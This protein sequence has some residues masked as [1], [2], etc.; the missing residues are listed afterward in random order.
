MLVK[1]SIE[2]KRGQES[3][4]GLDVGTYSS[5]YWPKKWEDLD[6]REKEKALIN[7]KEIWEN[8]MADEAESYITSDQFLLEPAHEL[9]VQKFGKKPYEIIGVSPL[10]D[11][12][13]RTL[14]YD[15][16]RKYVD[17]SD[18]I[19]I[20]DD[21]AF[22]QFL[23]ID[24]YLIPEVHYTITSDGIEFE[25]NDSE[26]EFTD[27]DLDHLHIAKINFEKY[28]N[29]LAQVIS[30]QAHYYY[31]DENLINHIEFNEIEFDPDLNPLSL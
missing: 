27:A 15:A 30:D 9:L 3:K 20:N 22:L 23:G 31:S 25:K 14:Y 13:P 16:D 24:D 26:Y 2:F 5:Q 28:L 1:E 18:S 21:E 7:F 6:K 12:D 10:I 17:V 4:K 8:N 29:D 11:F 19:Q